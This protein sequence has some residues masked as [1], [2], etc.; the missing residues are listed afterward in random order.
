MAEN[1]KKKALI[2]EKEST[3]D[4]IEAETKASDTTISTSNKSVGIRGDQP[5]TVS[6]IDNRK[7]AVPS[8][9]DVVYGK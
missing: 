3:K 6:A 1:L 9:I 7:A 8:Q 4:M 2:S 5:T